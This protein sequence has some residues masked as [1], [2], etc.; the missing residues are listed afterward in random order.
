MAQQ[1]STTVF[2]LASDVAV[3]I[4]ANDLV[5]NESEK[6]AIFSGKVRIQQGDRQI[7]CTKA[8]VHYQPAAPG[9]ASII[10]HIECE[11]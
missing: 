11:Q 8:V 6:R 1:S 7:D 10:T 4:A 2:H 5:V 3:Q 9:S